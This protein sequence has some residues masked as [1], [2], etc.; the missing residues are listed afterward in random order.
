MKKDEKYILT[1]LAYNSIIYLKIKKRDLQIY[2][3]KEKRKNE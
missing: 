3:I 2:K 1:L